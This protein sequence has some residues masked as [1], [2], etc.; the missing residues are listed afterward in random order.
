MDRT[1]GT[2]LQFGQ[3][4]TD[5]TALPPIDQEYL[6]QLVGTV[7]VWV[8]VFVMI[9]KKSGFIDYA[10]GLTVHSGV[11]SAFLHD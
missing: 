1:G 6:A 5:E 4:S 8:A 11:L 9:F 2:G 3:E 10:N 7:R